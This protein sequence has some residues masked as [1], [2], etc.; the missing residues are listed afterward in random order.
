MMRMRCAGG[1][2]RVRCVVRVFTAVRRVIRHLSARRRWCG[3][4]LP[5][6]MPA[7]Q[8]AAEKAR[9]QE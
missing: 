9:S 8:R 2:S 4:G 5:R 1:E 7:R 6:L 3:H